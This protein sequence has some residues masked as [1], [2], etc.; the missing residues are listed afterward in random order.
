MRLLDTWTGEFVEKDPRDPD[1]KYA[2]LSHTWNK[3]EQTYQ[4]L[5]DIQKQYDP[6]QNPLNDPLVRCPD[7][8]S[9]SLSSGSPES[10]ATTGITATQDVPSSSSHSFLRYPPGIAW[11]MTHLLWGSAPILPNPSDLSPIWDDP[12]LSPK[13][14]EA[15]KTARDHGHRYLWIDSCCIDKTS[16][17][18]LSEAINSMYQWYKLAVVCFAFLSDVSAE[19]EHDAEDS[20]FRRSLWFTR[21]W[22]LQELIAPGEVHFFSKEWTFIGSK[23]TLAHLINEITNISDTA[24]LH[25]ERLNTFSVAQRLSWAARRE[26]TRV[27]DQAYSLLGIF[28]INMP[29]LYGEGH[30]A[31]RRLQEEILRRIPDQ[32]LFAWGANGTI[33]S[34]KIAYRE[35]HY[36]SEPKPDI[37]LSSLFAHSPQHFRD[38]GSIN[39]ISPED[40]V[41]RL[42]LR[43]R[44]HLSIADYY[45]TPHGIRT[46]FPVIP[47]S[48]HFAR[49]GRIHWP[50]YL[51]ILQCEHKD[52][53]GQL[54]AR[55]CST[56]ASILSTDVQPLY[57]FGAK[58][59][60]T[61]RPAIP[62]LLHLSPETLTGL[63]WYLP[64]I[65]LYV[66]TF[67]IPHSDGHDESEG[68][69]SNRR[70]IW[71]DK[72]N[73]ILLKTTR[74]ALLAHG[75]A[76]VLRG[77]DQDHPDTH[78]LT[79]SRDTHTITIEYQ[80]SLVTTWYVSEQLFITAHWRVE[81]SE[82]SNPPN[83]HEV[84][85]TNS[86][87]L[88]WWDQQPWEYERNK[89]QDTFPSVQLPADIMG[90]EGW[91][92]D[93][94]PT[95]IRK[96]YY[97]LH[98]E[99]R[100]EPSKGPQRS[101]I[102]AW[103]EWVETMATRAVSRFTREKAS[104]G[105]NVGAESE[106]H[107]NSQGGSRAEY[108]D[109][110]CRGASEVRDEAPGELPSEGA[111]PS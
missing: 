38:C 46:Q 90:A 10:G 95:L 110:E 19:D 102:S 77:P 111:P 49:R 41:R 4:E 15:C 67:Y 53:P 29:T 8:P 42:P 45:Y 18:E 80:Y 27:E 103:K 30:R 52:Y 82:S 51:I 5:R 14:R 22:T 21:G 59:Q 107:G 37:G 16:S 78:W 105:L 87:T 40:V 96:N 64:R 56:P 86:G 3:V 108:T 35:A 55:T 94:K 62:E 47:F 43:H 57:N 70:K 1:T 109:G 72:I 13:I 44:F 48:K 23:H 104:L 33:E 75:Y 92:M 101:R 69:S 63:R 6:N 74:D 85:R 97:A 88:S 17:S 100:H 26:T 34:L 66:Q 83:F 32:T 79:L 58:A 31:F 36:S 91:W 76:V 2:I 24:L 84:A 12:E 25:I 93:S 7:G 28:D 54:L 71:H 99:I 11:I 89:S 65:N 60:P 98:I 50:T 9:G 68:S 73:L 61:N 20:S 39:P 106:G 81:A